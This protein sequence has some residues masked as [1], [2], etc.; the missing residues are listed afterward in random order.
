[1]PRPRPQKSAAAQVE[2]A[3][4]ALSYTHVPRGATGV[5][6][7][8]V[9][10]GNYVKPGT[11]L[12]AVVPNDL[13]ITAHFKETQLTRLRAGQPAEIKIDAYPDLTLTGHVDS[14]QPAA[15]DTFSASR[16]KR[17]R[18]LGEGGAARA[19]QDHAGRSPTIPAKPSARGCP[20]IPRRRV[21]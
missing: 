14:V 20:R 10:V 21:H 18:Q 9:A 12:M 2:Q 7:K 3:K 19:R 4:L 6:A 13:W 17:Q 8:T 1:M 15:G 16:A 5:F 11:A